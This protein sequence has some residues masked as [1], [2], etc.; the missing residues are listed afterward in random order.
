MEKQGGSS[1]LFESEGVALAIVKEISTVASIAMPIE[2]RWTVKRCRYAPQDGGGARLCIA[3]GIH[4]DEMMG[5]LIVFGIASRIMQQSEHLHGTVDLYPMLNPLGLDVGERMTPLSNMLD[6]NRAFPGVKDGTALEGMCYAV[7]QDMLGADLVLD[8]HASTQFK[9]ELF[10]VR[11]N[12][13]EA[14][15]LLPQARALGPDLIWI[16]PDRISYR[17]SLTSALAEAGTPALILEA[18]ERRRRPQDIAQRVVEGIFCKM[19]EMGL[20]TGDAQP[21]PP[22]NREIPC[23]R[24]P[25]DICRVTCERPGVYVPLD[26]LG[27]WVRAGDTLGQIIDALAGEIV[28]EVPAPADGLVFSQRS[29]SA[30]YPGTLIARVFTPSNAQRKGGDRA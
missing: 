24:K 7:M 4:G 15:E 16:Y 10:E 29:Y 19:T 14:A 5:Q 13:R 28:Q 11:M 17:A 22:A 25:E 9:S 6:M 20:W 23:I 26:R 27:E 3:T 12:A 21:L 18:D 1:P 30:V 2:E 8:I